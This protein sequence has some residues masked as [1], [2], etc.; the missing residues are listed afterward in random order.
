MTL[1]GGCSGRDLD[2][3]VGVGS[4]TGA[5]TGVGPE[6]T[7]RRGVQQDD[8]LLVTGRGEV[9]VVVPDRQEA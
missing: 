7:A 2:I 3:D 4:D 8:H 6:R 5:H 9:Q 1:Q